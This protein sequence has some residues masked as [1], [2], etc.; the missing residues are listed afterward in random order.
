M[1]GPAW[2]YVSLLAW[3]P[4]WHLLLPQPWGNRSWI[5]TLV[6]IIPLLLPLKGILQDSL[7]AMTWGGY[8]VLLYFVVGVMEAW[9]NDPQRWPAL[10]QALLAALFIAVTVAFSRREGRETSK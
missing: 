6:A 10:T 9:S 2:C 7:R 5:I 8:L 3:Q 4:A 1:S